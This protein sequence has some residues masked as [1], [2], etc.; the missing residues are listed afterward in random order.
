MAGKI[1]Q[2]N[3]SSGFLRFFPP[4]KFLRMP[5]VGLDISDT[6]VRFMELSP[7][8]GGYKAG[9]FGGER[10]PA[11]VITGGYIQDKMELARILRIIKEKNGFNFV[12]VSMPEEKAYFFKTQVP[13]LSADEVRQAIEFKLEENVPIGAGEA[14][15]DYL[16]IESAGQRS[17][18][19]DVMVSVIP[20]KTS[21]AYSEVLK[22][23]GLFPKTFLVGIQAVGAAV[24]SPSDK[25]TVILITVGETKAGLAVVS[26]GVVYFASTV[27]FGPAGENNLSNK[28]DNQTG[29]GSNILPVLKDEI[30]KM[31]VYW[32]T[33]EEASLGQPEK[34]ILTGANATLGGLIE[35]LGSATGLQTELANVWQKVFDLNRSLPPIPFVE[36][37]D[38]AAAI[39]LALIS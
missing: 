30:H 37:L 14:V 27:V 10:L 21:A 6:A 5:A 16:P 12:N 25:K 36:S 31:T 15:F 11:G 29:S 9:H 35:D 38:Y 17:D 33:R 23:A 28:T 34:I 3:E 32:K 2:S 4:P 7:V 13:K 19:L 18:H 26:G 8:A 20:R 39:G 24:I 1:L 22:L